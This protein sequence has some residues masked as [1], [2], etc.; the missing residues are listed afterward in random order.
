[1]SKKQ[2]KTVK[3][4]TSGYMCAGCR[5]PINVCEIEDGSQYY[6]QCSC[7]YSAIKKM[8]ELKLS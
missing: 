7:C 5:Q 8:V 2:R 6:E 3:R 4:K 1:M